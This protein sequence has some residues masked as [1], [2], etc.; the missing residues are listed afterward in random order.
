MRTLPVAASVGH[1]ET[2]RKKKNLQKQK[3]GEIT[4]PAVRATVPT[5]DATNHH[6]LR[7]HTH[8]ADLSAP[9]KNT[10]PRPTTPSP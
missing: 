8:A 7:P 1:N 5:Y 4:Q 2:I 10:Y 3:I 6:T 9:Q